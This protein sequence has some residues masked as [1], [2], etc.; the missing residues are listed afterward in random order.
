MNI[1]KLLTQKELA[2][3]LSVSVQTV[4]RWKECPRI[5]V[6]KRTNG[7]GSA[8]RYDLAEVIAWLKENRSATNTQI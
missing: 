6:G 4:R 1:Q 2:A 3:A 7:K 8:C 5:Y